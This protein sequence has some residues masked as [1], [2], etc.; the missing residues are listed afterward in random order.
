MHVA[1]VWTLGILLLITF[2][3]YLLPSL[4]RPEL[5]FGVT[6]P[7][8]F[9]ESAAGRGLIRIYRLQVWLIAA[10]ALVILFAGRGWNPDVV[11]A[12]ATWW[13][14]VAASL[15][16]YA[17]NRMAKPYAVA[18]STEREALLTSD[19]RELPGNW[20]LHL[21]PYVIVAAAALYLQRNYDL[22]P[23]PYPVHFNFQGVAD[24][25]EPKTPLTVFRPLVV[26]FVICVSMKL[27]A[28]SIARQSKRISITGAAARRE[29]RFRGMNLAVLL[30]SEYHVACSLAW[31]TVATRLPNAMP[32]ALYVMLAMTIVLILAVIYLS[33][34]YGQGGSRLGDLS[35]ETLGLT[36]AYA[37]RKDLAAPIGDRTPDECWKFGQLYFNPDDPAI[38]VEKRA[39]VGYT[40]N[41]G[42]PASWAIL[43]AITG[44]P[45]V[46][47]RL[48]R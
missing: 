23:D 21:G 16:W 4:T 28:F 33:A 18:P 2:M 8:D 13:L 17:A 29:T 10:I 48:M 36:D 31:M 37:S 35:T 43:L 7:R 14:A 40:L 39:G 12:A 19:S 24:S 45:L 30:A 3:I 25:F 5:F 42:R 26:A 47:I 11:S 1:T 6:V 38:W 41:F 34:R 44:A 27:T 22:L 15:A 9:R 46:V 32:F 20:I